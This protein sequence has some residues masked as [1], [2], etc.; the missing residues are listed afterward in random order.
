MT[1]SRTIYSSNGSVKAEFVDGILVRGT[2]QDE[3][4]LGPIIIADLPDY[5]SP[6]DGHIISGRV[7][8][9]NDMARTG[10]RPWE[11]MQQEQKEAARQ[12]NYESQR[13]DRQLDHTMEKSWHQLSENTRRTLSNY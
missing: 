13:E 8:R 2:L 4:Q 1:R 3:G 7:A 9:R 10:C 11:G 5:E 6:I 12:Q